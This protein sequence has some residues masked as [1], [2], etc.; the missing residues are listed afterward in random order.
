MLNCGATVDLDST[1]NPEIPVYVIDAHR[2]CHLANLFLST[3]VTIVCD[4]AEVDED[5]D[6]VKHAFE[7]IHVFCLFKQIKL[8]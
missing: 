1:L 5:L 6:I 2:P 4:P 3:Q 8:I 7:R